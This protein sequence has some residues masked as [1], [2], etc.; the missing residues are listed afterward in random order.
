[1][2]KLPFKET[3]KRAE[4][5]LQVIHTDTME[6]IE[7]TPYPGLKRLIVV[8]VDDFSRFAIVHSVKI[9]YSVKFSSKKSNIMFYMLMILMKF[10]FVPQTFFR[11][12]FFLGS[13]SESCA[14][15]G[16]HY[17]IYWRKLF[18]IC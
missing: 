10:S 6:P 12:F 18:F 14:G 3:R 17:E 7:P 16:F 9:V 8:F 2:E 4:R 1:M 15:A 11:M 5:P 13:G